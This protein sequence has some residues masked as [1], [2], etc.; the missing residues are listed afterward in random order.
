[1][2][3]LSLKLNLTMNYL[4]TFKASYRA[5]VCCIAMALLT[6]ISAKAQASVDEDNVDE[7]DLT[8]AA[9][10]GGTDSLKKAL[11]K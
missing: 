7:A 2:C 6:S 9:P 11:G 4:S 3:G 1:M 8:G 10:S 5:V